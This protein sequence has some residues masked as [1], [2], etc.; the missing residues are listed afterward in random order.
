MAWKIKYTIDT[1]SNWIKRVCIINADTREKALEILDR[2]IVSKLKGK[3]I[4][5]HHRT[6][7][8]ECT[9]IVL[10]DGER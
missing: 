1:G 9:G 5:R 8:T 2:E 6:E 4:I 7:I 10:Y 3:R